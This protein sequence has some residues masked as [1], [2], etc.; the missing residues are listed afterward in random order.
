MTKDY[1]LFYKGRPCR[2]HGWDPD[3]NDGRLCMRFSK[4]ITQEAFVEV[5][6][7]LQMVTVKIEYPDDT[8]ERVKADRLRGR[9]ERVVWDA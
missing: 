4:P 3:G 2:I 6:L 8:C 5:W 9:V 7:R 1:P